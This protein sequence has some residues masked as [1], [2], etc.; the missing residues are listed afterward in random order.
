MTKHEQY[1]DMINW[2][3]IDP[4][5]KL[6]RATAC[7]V[8]RGILDKKGVAKLFPARIFVDNSLLLEI[9]RRLMQMALTALIEAIF[10]IMGNPDTAI[11]Q[12][13]LAMDKWVDMVAGPIQTMLGLVINT[14]ELTVKIPGP[15]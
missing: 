11:R 9:C 12:C 7:A 10:V 1:M 4:T 8:N 15:Y 5:V 14:N 6:M 13:P 2:A 3:T